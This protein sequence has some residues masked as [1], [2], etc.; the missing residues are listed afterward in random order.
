MP[1]T[2]IA[3]PR[4]RQSI[5]AQVEQ[6]FDVTSDPAAKQRLLGR[7]SNY[8]RCPFCG[9]EGPLA[10][11]IVYHD[12]EKELLLTYF[13]PELGLP[14]NEQ[15][16]LIGPLISQVTNKL[17]AEKR[18]GYL[19]RPQSFL[20]YQSMIEKILEKDG[21]TKE[22][23][24]EQQKRVSLIQ[25]L[26]EATS[27]EVRTA[28]IKENTAMLDETFFALFNR[29]LEAALQ[30]GQQSAAQAMAALQEELLEHSD[31]GRKVRAQMGELEAA[32]KSL[33]EAG[34]GLT[35]EKLLDIFLAAPT[36]ARLQ[37]LVSMTRNGLDYSFFQILT[38]R[39][40][41]SSG[42][43]R[44]KLE[45]L[46]TKVLDYTNQIDK[47][48]EEQ[49]K[50][51]EQ[52]IESIL[53]APD[54][55]QATVQNLSAFQSDVVV[56]VLES[57]LQE[58]NR[59][60]DSARMQKLQQMVAVLQQASTPPELA[61]INELLEVADDETVLAHKLK[62]HEAEIGEE[63]SG[64]IAGLMNQVEQQAAKDPNSGEILKRLETLYRAILK[65]T[66]Q[67]NLG[68]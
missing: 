52:M 22:M 47:A 50:Q 63:L 28:I 51:A 60:M 62:E 8:A 11:P 2:Q 27:P 29:L 23:L 66:M 12:N 67:K 19:L 3:C 38:E 5:P 57:K 56:Q 45:D 10:T 54:V 44:A 6:L 53:A 55:A 40:E 41:K 18:K 43:E 24:D 1:Q 39:I 35:R 17:P 4:C 42:A 21:V 49:M 14:I 64:M 30:S 31:Y 34:Q 37:A 33:Q 20:T 7:V 36:E 59:K 25:R 9:F 16:K 61:L 46:R 26:M 48:V 58:A 15:E 65:K 32:V 13:P 68:Q